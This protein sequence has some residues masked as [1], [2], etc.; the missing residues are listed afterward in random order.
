[1]SSEIETEIQNLKT[2]LA[3]CEQQ[4]LAQQGK[5]EGAVTMREAREALE[6][7]D[8]SLMKQFCEQ[9]DERRSLTPPSMPRQKIAGKQHQSSAGHLVGTTASSGDSH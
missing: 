9:E 1:M 3:W 4:L 5:Q 8:K 6:R 2:R 7:G